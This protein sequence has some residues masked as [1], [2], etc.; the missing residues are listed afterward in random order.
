MP[1]KDEVWF[2]PDIT[3]VVHRKCT[4]SCTLPRN[5][6]PIYD[7]T[8]VAAGTGWY[9]INGKH[10]DV[11]PGDL[12]CT[13]PGSTREARTS[14][15]RLLSVYAVDFHLLEPGLRTLP[16]KIKTSIGR[17]KELIRT[18]S[19][20]NFTWMEKQPGYAIKSHGL[21]LL[22]LHRAYELCVLD[23]EFAEDD[24][25]IRKAVRYIAAHYT[26]K[27]TVEK[28]AAM[29]GLEPHYFNA[30]FKRQTG[31]SM[32]QYLIKI[33]I[34]NAYNMLVTGEYKVAEI[35]EICGYSDIYHFHKQFKMV[36]DIS[37]SQC[38]P[39]G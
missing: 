14:L 5:V 8:Y 12:L 20:M 1:D 4:P 28:M 36:M 9:I 10:Y 34:K 21:L 13:P 33:R 15:D 25:R 26:E 23:L 19:E 22:I 27:L 24:Y 35:A 16:F 31:L 39:R 7:L 32:H 38:I 37:P 11:G 3:Y 29:T 30:L 6:M 17:R 18:F 2:V